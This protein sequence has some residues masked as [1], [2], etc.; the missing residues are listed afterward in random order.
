VGNPAHK[1]SAANMLGIGGYFNVIK[2]R[3]TISRGGAYNTDLECMFVAASKGAQD[4]V[5][6]PADCPTSAYTVPV[7]ESP[8]L[9]TDDLWD[10]LG[11]EPDWEDPDAKPLSEDGVEGDDECQ[12][13]P[14]PTAWYD[15]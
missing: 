1:G 14:S 7:D 2:V 6:S 3:S 11:P 13:D 15:W 9:T 5:D 4:G 10:S 8:W 12:G